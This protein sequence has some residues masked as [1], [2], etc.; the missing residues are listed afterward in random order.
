[1]NLFQDIEICLK[2]GKVITFEIK[3]QL[4]NVMFEYFATKIIAHHNGM[5]YFHYNLVKHLNLYK[6]HNVKD[7]VEDKIKLN[8]IPNQIYVIDDWCQYDSVLLS[9]ITK[10]LFNPYNN[11]IVFGDLTMAKIFKNIESVPK[12]KFHKNDIVLHLRLNDFN[13]GQ[14]IQPQYIVNILQ[15]LT[16]NNLYLVFDK[17]KHKFE[18]EYISNFKKF[19]PILICGNLYEDISAL[20]NAPRLI[21]STSTLCWIFGSLGNNWM[22]WVPTNKEL[23]TFSSIFTKDNEKHIVWHNYMLHQDVKRIKYN[24]QS[25]DTKFQDKIY[26]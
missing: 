9:S 14:I 8:K 26:I 4:G 16:W 2:L 10:S 25:Y 20:Y 15:T 3:G 23:P 22:S 17:V 7:L 12:I 24:S 5:E 11:D 6:I 19:N 21:C 13:H 18:E 1:M